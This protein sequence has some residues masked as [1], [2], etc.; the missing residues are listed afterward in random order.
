MPPCWYCEKWFRN[1]QKQNESILK[2]DQSVWS[3]MMQKTTKFGSNGSQRYKK[4]ERRKREW[5]V[6][7]E[8]KIRW[9][10]D[11]EK[12]RSVPLT[13]SVFSVCFPP[14]CFVATQFC[15][16][17][18]TRTTSLHR[19]CWRRANVFTLRWFIFYYFNFVVCRLNVLLQSVIVSVSLG[20]HVGTTAVFYERAN[21]S[22]EGS[23][24]R[25]QKTV[26]LALRLWL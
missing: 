16:V 6:E 5:E 15:R 9:E 2:A 1:E 24:C 10:W 11:N 14:N 12:S 26:Q 21:S 23:A 13:K 22:V 19:T 8:W 17:E 3:K 20:S 25:C 18:R 7:R 4:N